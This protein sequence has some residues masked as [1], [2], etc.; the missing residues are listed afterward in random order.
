M[1]KS[2][3]ILA[4]NTGEVGKFVRNYQIPTSFEGL[5]YVP[6]KSKVTASCDDVVQL[7]NKVVRKPKEIIAVALGEGTKLCRDWQDLACGIPGLKALFAK[8]GTHYVYT[9]PIAGATKTFERGHISCYYDKNKN[10][11][12]F[13]V[14]DWNTKSVRMFN[15]Q[16]KLTTQY[17]P[18]ETMALFK[19]KSD[20]RGIHY[21]L[22]NGGRASNETDLKNTIRMLSQVFES[23]KTQ[24]TKDW[25]TG[26]RAL[27]SISLKRI[28]AMPNDGMMFV[29]P[30][31]ISVATK[32][33]SVFPFL[34]FRNFNHIL[35]VDIPPNTKYLNLDEIGH[36]I[37]PQVPENE[38]L[39]E[40]GT[41]LLIKKRD[42]MI[43]AELVNN[44]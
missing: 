12:R 21:I 37:N 42:G 28:L 29:D 43:C 6:Q 5:R 2:L 19:Y 38:L 15:G 18:E 44:K 1:Q 25:V 8:R 17:T 11:S 20:S 33:S 27:D 40:A 30:S 31:F 4:D 23:G 41:R 16:G 7:V 13:Y 9:K 3:S 39:L 32:K 36:I 24:V 10:L 26:Y 34:N 35:K 22:R 14:F